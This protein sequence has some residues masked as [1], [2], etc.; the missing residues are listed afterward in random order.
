MFEDNLFLSQI[1][2]KFSSNNFYS[3]FRTPSN[4]Q[5]KLQNHYNKLILLHKNNIAPLN[6]CTTF[7]DLHESN[8][9]I[10]ESSESVT[11][12]DLE[13][14]RISHPIFDLSWLITRVCLLTNPQKTLAYVLPIIDSFF[15]DFEQQNH[16]N[17]K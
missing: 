15:E 5:R 3:F 10:N 1:Y 9:I 16:V 12:V 6:K 13:D 7:R 8:L 17:V 11:I 2:G 14:A 4:F